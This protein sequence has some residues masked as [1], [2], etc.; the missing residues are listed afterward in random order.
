MQFGYKLLTTSI[1]FLV[2][3]ADIHDCTLGGENFYLL[4]FINE[5]CFFIYF[6]FEE[7]VLN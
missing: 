1:N 4:S 2:S 7:K 6:I 5:L 3:P